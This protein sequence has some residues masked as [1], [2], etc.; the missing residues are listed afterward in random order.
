[1]KVVTDKII[2]S[3]NMANSFTSSHILLDQIY[4][5]SLH[6]VY[7]GSPVGTF[8][9]QVSNQDVQLRESVTEWTDLGSSSV[10]VSASGSN[11]WNISDAFYRWVRVVYTKTSGTGSCTIT[12]TSKG[13]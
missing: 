5:Y 11:M 13:I 7:S 4:G 1:M 2:E 8:K 9:L 12:M 3:Q 6:A 10:S